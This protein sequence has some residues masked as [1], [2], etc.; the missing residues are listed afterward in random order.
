[1]L[2][3]KPLEHAPDQGHGVA[4]V[5]LVVREQQPG[6]LVDD[7]H[8]HRGGPGVNANVDR[9]GI[10][11]AKGGPGNLRPGV[12]GLECLVFLPGLKQ[13]RLAPVSLGGP[14][15]PEAVRQRA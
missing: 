6:L 8:L 2:I 7:G 10:V 11:R 13:R 3:V 5:G 12:A 15:L 4:Q 14:P 9:S 1:M